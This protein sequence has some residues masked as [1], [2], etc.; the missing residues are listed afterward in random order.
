M[1]T[2]AVLRGVRLSAQKGRLVADQIRGMPVDKALNLLSFSPKKGA[3]IIRKVLESAIANAEHNDGADIDEL[4]VTTIHVEQGAEPQAFHAARQGSWIQDH[5]AHLP[6]LCD[7]RGQGVSMGQKIHPTGFRL[8]VNKNWT[9]RWYSNSKNFPAMLHEDIKV[10]DFLKKKLAHAAVSKV[11]IERPAKNAKITVL[12]RPSRR[13]DRQEGRGHRESARTAAEAD[14]RAGACQHRRSAQAGNRCAADRRFHRAAT[15]KAHH[16][17]P[18]D[19]ACD[20]ERHAPGRAG[21]QD[22]ELRAV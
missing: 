16:V 8:A 6:H 14:G 17:P 15:G 18:R 5:Q 19:E 10:R 4:T 7:G 12:Q 2:S 1:K 22:H 11:V 21:H 3:A 9:S 13:G 20:A